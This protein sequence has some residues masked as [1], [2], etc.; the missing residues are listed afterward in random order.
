MEKLGERQKEAVMRRQSEIRKKGKRTERHLQ[1]GLSVRWK[2]DSID[3]GLEI[4]TSV[5]MP[6]RI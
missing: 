4:E 1:L 2:S 6:P 3:G 5:L